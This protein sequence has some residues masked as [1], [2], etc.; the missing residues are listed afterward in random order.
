MASSVDRL[1]KL[2]FVF[3]VADVIRLGLAQGDEHTFL[4]R[5]VKSERIASAGFKSG[6][7]FNLLR[8][9]NARARVL[10]AARLAYPSA[11][12]VGAA[13]LHAHG[14]TTQVPHTTDLAVM[15]RRSRRP[16]RGIHFVER[17]ADWYR[18]HANDILAPGE[19][20]FELHALTP[21]AALADAKAN[22]DLWVPD[23]DDIDAHID[24]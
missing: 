20:G 12:V 4:A 5:A 6:I 14:W 16:I 11:V 22:G 10:E 2:P 19:S 24:A 3:A 1:L 13:V 8:D 17:K 9:P 23:A 7:Y 15:K 18:Q 21:A